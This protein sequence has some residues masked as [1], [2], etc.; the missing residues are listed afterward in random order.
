MTDLIPDLSVGNL[1]VEDYIYSSTKLSALLEATRVKHYVID[2]IEG[3]VI[4]DKYINPLSICTLSIDTYK[5]EIYGHPEKQIANALYL[6]ESNYLDGYDQR[7]INVASPTKESDAANKKYVDDMIN[8]VSQS[9][10]YARTTQQKSALNQ[11]LW[12][13]YKFD[14][15]FIELP[16]EFI[17]VNIALGKHLNPSYNSNAYLGIYEF[18]SNIGS[19][20]T[21]SNSTLPYRLI[22]KSNNTDLVIKSYSGT[23]VYSFNGIKIQKGKT[24]VFAF[25]NDQ[26][27]LVNVDM[28]LT[29]SID[30]KTIYNNGVYNDYSINVI[31]VETAKTGMPYINRFIMPDAEDSSILYNVELSGGNWNIQHI[32]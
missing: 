9:T 15:D 21:Q 30:M 28:T 5:T 3:K 29:K 1:S 24:Y 7:V 31:A 16:D 25:I 32:N 2:P 19:L 20:Q 18:N 14:N 11:V 23:L 27:E 13:T 6:I 10:Y 4:F 17:L 26:N 12:C 8:V 22:A